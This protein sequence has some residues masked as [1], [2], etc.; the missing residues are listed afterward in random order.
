MLKINDT[1]YDLNLIDIINELKLQLAL[2]GINLFSRIK[3]LPQDLMV[4]CP[5]HKNGQE[6]KPSCGIRKEDGYLHCFSCG[7]SCSLEQLIGRCFGKYDL[8]QYG[9][10]WLKNNFLGDLYKERTIYIDMQRNT[11]K[12]NSSTKY[13]DDKE[14]DEYR[15]WHPYMKKRK[16]TDDVIELFDIGYDEKTDCITFPIKDWKGNCLFIARRSVKGKYFNYPN[17]VEKPVYGIYELYQQKE[18][19]QEIYIC[20]SMIDALTLWGIHKYAVAL[21]GLGTE[22]QFKQLNEIPCR[23]FILATDNDRAGMQ[24]RK[25]IV[26]KLKNKIITQVILPEGKKD[27][28]ECTFDELENLQEVFMN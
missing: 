18:F 21:N 8:G 11:V 1:Y 5:F 22:Y 3:D 10:N 2:Q 12:T 26:N 23:K 4:S 15:Y 16:L 27:I 13:I 20:E 9:L 7:E 19:P 24:A 14:L 25:V 28:N 6:K 17:N